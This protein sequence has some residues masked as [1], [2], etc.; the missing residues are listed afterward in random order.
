[1]GETLV[2]T[3]V[4]KIPFAPFAY[5]AAFACAMMALVYLARVLE[6]VGKIRKEQ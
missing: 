1:M 3:G 4:L 2:R 5:L 6:T